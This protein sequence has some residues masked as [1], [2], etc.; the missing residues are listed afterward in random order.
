MCL[1][2]TLSAKLEITLLRQQA[3]LFRGNEKGAP[4]LLYRNFGCSEILRT[5]ERSSDQGNP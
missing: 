3:A 1:R 2:E 5:S 4:K